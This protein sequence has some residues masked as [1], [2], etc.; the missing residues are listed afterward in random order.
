MKFRKPPVIEVWISIEFQP[1]DNKRGFD[2]ELVQAFAVQYKE[3]FPNRDVEH[4]VQIQTEEQA[5]NRLPKVVNRDVKLKHVRLWNEARSRAFQINDDQI[6]YHMLKNSL[7]IP[8]YQ[9]VRTATEPKL[10]DYINK[11]RPVKITNAVLHYLDVIEIP[12][13]E[14]D[15][16]D[17]RDYFLYSMEIP[18]D[19]FGPMFNFS[20]SFEVVCPIDDGPLFVRLQ[21]LPSSGTGIFRFQMEWHKLSRGIDTLDPSAVWKRLNTAHDYMWDCFINSFSEKTL[22]LFEPIQESSEA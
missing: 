16:I 12:V 15:K 9:K 8:G 18:E 4:E 3:D 10:L 17:L 22:K 2:P 20:Q 14:N 13:P 11:F 5:S 1:N 6:S 7:E 19:P 21:S